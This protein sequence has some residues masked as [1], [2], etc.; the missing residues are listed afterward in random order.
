MLQILSNSTRSA[1]DSLAICFP[2]C[3]S[4][5]RSLCLSVSLS[6]CLS[7]C[8]SVVCLSVCLFAVC[9]SVSMSVSLSV[10]LPV[11]LR[12]VL[13]DGHGGHVHPPKIFN[14]G[15]CNCNV[16]KY[17]LK[18]KKGCKQIAENC[19]GGG[20]PR[21][22]CTPLVGGP[23]TPLCL[24][25]YFVGLSACLPVSLSFSSYLHLSVTG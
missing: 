6:V 14:L 2:V 24:S 19:L 1:S 7:V 20:S 13:G 25:T 23:S 12:R 22:P 8:L 18:F 9:L 11:C 5:S 15:N 17:A 4:V 16:C 3:L 10:L 21:L